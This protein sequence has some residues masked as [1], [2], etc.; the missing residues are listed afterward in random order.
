M[1]WNKYEVKKKKHALLTYAVESGLIMLHLSFHTSKH[2]HHCID[3]KKLLWYTL[4]PQNMLHCTHAN[5]FWGTFFLWTPRDAATEGHQPGT[6]V[7]TIKESKPSL[8][9]EVSVNSYQQLTPHSHHQPHDCT[10]MDRVKNR[11]NAHAL[12]A[13]CKDTWNIVCISQTFIRRG[14][15]QP[16]FTSTACGQHSTEPPG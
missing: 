11:L 9:Q 8:L 12:T 1:L 15:T 14:E 7:V 16:R 2:M 13:A 4:R 5:F 10:R 6:E 3:F